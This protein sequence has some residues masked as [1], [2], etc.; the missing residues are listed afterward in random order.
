MKRDVE[1]SAADFGRMHVPSKMNADQVQDYMTLVLS[2]AEQL[3]EHYVSR[4][5]AW[6]VVE[7]DRVEG[8][9]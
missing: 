7:L 4:Q 9:A 1:I 5:V 3:G 8:T 2:K 6:G